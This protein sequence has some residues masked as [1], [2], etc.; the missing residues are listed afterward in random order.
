MKRQFEAM[1]RDLIVENE[2]EKRFAL[3]EA[4]HIQH[5]QQLAMVLHANNDKNPNVTVLFK[6]LS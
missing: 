3:L 6:G 5:Q 4:Q 2:M 1:K